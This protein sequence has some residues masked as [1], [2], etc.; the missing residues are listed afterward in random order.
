MPITR[1][2]LIVALL[3]ASGCSEDL[4]EDLADAAPAPQVDA[5]TRCP[6]ATIVFLNMDGG[7]YVRGAASDP[8]TNTSN[9]LTPDSVDVAA[10]QLSAAEQ[11]EVAT[12][13]RE[14]VA[15]YNIE[16]VTADPADTLHHEVVLTSTAPAALGVST[17]TSISAFSCQPFINLAFVFTSQHSPGDTRRICEDT[18]LNMLR[19]AHVD[20][21]FSCNQ[22][23]SYLTG[24]GDKGIHDEVV[25]CG[26][27][28]ARPCACGGTTLNP[29]TAMLDT[30]G[31]TC[32]P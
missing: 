18:V 30:F 11:T 28:E 17:V 9:I 20:T 23:A 16:V 29:H 4:T 14:L 26:E 13:V 8:M 15:P 24:C 27:F 21:V 7:T 3:T 5:L 32:N 19:T 1:T 25:S 31:G 2:V 10:T 12:C 6:G 22:V